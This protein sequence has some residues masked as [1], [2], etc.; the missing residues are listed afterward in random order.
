MFIQAW[1]LRPPYAICTDKMILFLS[2]YLSNI[3]AYPW[4]HPL[5]SAPLLKS[6]PQILPA[7]L[8]LLGSTVYLILL[9][10]G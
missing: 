2:T 7:E 10:I 6:Y 9:D 5:S 4:H 8:V 3:T 1:P